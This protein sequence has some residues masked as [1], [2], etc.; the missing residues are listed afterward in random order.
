MNAMNFNE[1]QR[2]EVR[3]G[4][5]RLLTEPAQLK[6]RMEHVPSADELQWE[7]DG[8]PA[9][10]LVTEMTVEEYHK[11]QMRLRGARKQSAARIARPF[12]SSRIVKVAE[13][14]PMRVV[15]VRLRDGSERDEQIAALEAQV[16]VLL[17]LV[18]APIVAAERKAKSIERFKT[19]FNVERKVR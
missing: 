7:D 2:G 6:V 19:L 8:G 4:S 16:E 18:R 11:Q 17:G 15:A 9:V 10:E 1:F 12:E 3:G 5:Y 13:P 14:A